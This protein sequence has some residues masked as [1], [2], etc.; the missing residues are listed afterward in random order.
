MSFEVHTGVDQAKAEAR[1]KLRLL[2]LTRGGTVLQVALN[3]GSQTRRDARELW[4]EYAKE[5]G[6][7]FRVVGNCMITI[8]HERAAS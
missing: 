5:L 6:V 3:G 8:G 1:A 7:P 4:E 2:A